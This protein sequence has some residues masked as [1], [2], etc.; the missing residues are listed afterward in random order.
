VEA[1]I[2]QAGTPEALMEVHDEQ[3]DTAVSHA[4]TSNPTEPIAPGP[5]IASSG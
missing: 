4:A 3:A 5:A 2:E 1:H